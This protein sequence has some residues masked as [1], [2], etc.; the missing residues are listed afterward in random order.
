MRHLH[1]DNFPLYLLVHGWDEA[2]VRIN[3]EQC[4]A[5]WATVHGNV[6][7]R[8][9]PNPPR[10]PWFSNGKI[11]GCHADLVVPHEQYCEQVEKGRRP[12]APLPWEERLPIGFFRGTS[13]GF[14]VNGREA[15]SVRSGPENHRQRLVKVMR[16]HARHFD[17]G[18]TDRPAGGDVGAAT[19]PLVEWAR[20]RYHV[21]LGGNTYS[22]RLAD[23]SRI[24]STLI[25]VSAF[26]DSFSMT[27][28]EGEHYLRAAFDG[29]DL[30]A[31]KLWLDSHPDEARRLGE[32][33]T[34]HYEDNWDPV[35]QVWY[36]VSLLRSYSESVR[37]VA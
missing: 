34:Q 18:V 4:N 24:N 36:V 33:L 23:I 9:L 10:L 13:T 8:H 32:A 12:I 14:G 17:V 16:A 28:S 21:D 29:S 1:A 25:A 5:R 7:N 19:V 27:L 35:G 15:E 26:D 3:E 22:P 2:L 30:L 31:K 37:W 6:W 20:W 11:V